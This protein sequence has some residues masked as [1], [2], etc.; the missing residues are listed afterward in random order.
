MIYDTFT[1]NGEYDLLEIRLSILADFVDKFIIVESKE[2]FSGKPKT[3]YYEKE[4]ERY[5][6]WHDKIEYYVIPDVYKE[7]Y[8]AMASLSPNTIGATHWK[9]EFCQKEAI[10]DAL[11]NLKDSDVC[12][13]GDVDE[14]WY[15]ERIDYFKSVKEPE[16]LKLQVYSYFVNNRSD[17]EF[18]GTIVTKYQD[19]RGACLNHLR[20]NSRKTIDTYGDHFTSMGGYEEVKRKLSDSYTRES[21]WTEEVEDNLKMNIDSRLDFLGRD[22]TCTLSEVDL[23]KYVLDN[24]NKYGHLFA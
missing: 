17:E 18:W 7:K 3:L 14:I 21:Y 23:P 12:F 22:F 5:K 1:F 6:K 10:K 9:T 8:M 13:I 4:K 20:V 16:K 15:P 11:V 24:K 2:T 19:V